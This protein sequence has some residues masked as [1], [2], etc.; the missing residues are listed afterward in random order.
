[1]VGDAE[2]RDYAVILISAIRFWMRAFRW[3]SLPLG[4]DLGDVVGDLGERFLREWLR[5]VGELIDE[6]VAA[7]AELLGLDLE[8]GESSG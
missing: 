7:G 6:L 4:D 8:R 3:L 2:D 1:M 5:E